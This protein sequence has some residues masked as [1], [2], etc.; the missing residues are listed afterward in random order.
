M[1]TKHQARTLFRDDPIEIENIQIPVGE[2]DDL[3]PD[4]ATIVAK[5][6]AAFLESIRQHGILSP[7]VLIKR[8]R[9]KKFDLA[10]GRRR[11]VAAKMTEQ[12]TLPAR[13]YPFGTAKASILALVENTNRRPNILAEWQAVEDLIQANHTEDEIFSKT[14]VVKARQRQLLTLRNLVNDLRVAFEQG[15]IKASL[16]LRLA[17]QRPVV[18][19]KLAESF[20]ETGKLK[21]GDIAEIRKIA[22][23]DAV[24]ALPSSLFG[25]EKIDWKDKALANLRSLQTQV[26]AVAPAEF[27]ETL[28][29]FIEATE[30]F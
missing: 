30:Q 17:Q 21:L 12:I 4:A 2:I 7:V 29:G 15:K 22:K 25:D 13:V 6:D 23:G 24:A 26:E 5:P 11:I 8:S 9:G 14:G 19:R 3:I 20:K 16:A 28:K 27:I 1:S 18:Q 10:F